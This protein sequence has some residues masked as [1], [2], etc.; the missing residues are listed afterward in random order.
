M[1]TN[2]IM[3]EYE[4]NHM[5]IDKYEDMELRLEGWGFDMERLSQTERGRGGVSLSP[6]KVP[7]ADFTNV[8][9]T[10]KDMPGF[11]G[12]TRQLNNLSIYKND[13]LKENE[14]CHYGGL[15]NP[16]AYQ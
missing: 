9:P 4:E 12:T 13:T 10:D 11:E 3:Y 1:C 15:P 16:N 5:P 7:R 14:W 2:G 6:P 8:H